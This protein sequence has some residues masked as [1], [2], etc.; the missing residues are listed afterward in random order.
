[1]HGE[2]Q[3][4]MGVPS[5]HGQSRG[6]ESSPKSQ[7]RSKRTVNQDQ[8]A[9]PRVRAKARRFELELEDVGADKKPIVNLATNQ[10]G[11]WVGE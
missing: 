5:M 7:P 3:A 9:Q 10:Q 1:M 2:Y 4:C 8:N 6:E 11:G